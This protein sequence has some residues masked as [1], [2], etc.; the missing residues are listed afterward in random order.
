MNA[1]TPGNKYELANTDD[2][3][4]VQTLQF[5]ERKV[6]QS[7][8]LSAKGGAAGQ[9]KIVVSVDG[10][11]ATEVLTALIDRL[12]FSYS[13]FN[14]IQILLAAHHC[15]LALAQLT[16]LAAGLKAQGVENAPLP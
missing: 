4:V 5:I 9:A 2:P 10:V 13:R 12:G 11:S 16:D 1:T 15:E 3:G 6:E 7:K 8:V 14:T